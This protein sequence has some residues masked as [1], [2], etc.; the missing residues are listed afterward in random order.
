[1]TVEGSE[2]PRRHVSEATR[3]LR[4]QAHQNRAQ[5]IV[6]ALEWFDAKVETQSRAE[7]AREWWQNCSTEAELHLA[8]AVATWVLHPERPP[9]K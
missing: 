7:H 2:K 5:V 6:A 1:M 8:H 4:G 3:A 9:Q